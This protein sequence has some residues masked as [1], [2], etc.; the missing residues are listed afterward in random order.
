MSL[1]VFHP[2]GDWE[3]GQ[4]LTLDGDE[5]RYVL[6][7]RRAGPGTALQVLDGQAQAWDA[8][9]AEVRGRTAMV[10]LHAALPSPPSVPLHLLLAMPEPRATL[11]ALTLACELGATDVH[12]VH[13][14]H[15]PGGCPSPERMSK[16]L[17]AA[18]RQ[19]G[20]PRPPRIHGPG[21]LADALTATAAQPGFVAS[22][23]ERHDPAPLPALDPQLG[24]R[25]LVGPE[26][27]LSPAERS[28]A[29]E[30]G[31]R[32]LSLGPWVLRTPTAVTAGLARLRGAAD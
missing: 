24:A 25:L 16:T 2:P 20:Q 6:R 12:L 26:G 21:A 10:E 30:A 1:R 27:G 19:C 9:V 11:E 32:S 3:V 5:S 4:T 29:R 15:S 13:G 14:D 17:R 8:T 18:Q 7:V 23:P 31:L 22:A 28:L